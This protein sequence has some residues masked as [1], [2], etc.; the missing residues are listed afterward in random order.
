MTDRSVV[1]RLRL[2]VGNFV[3]NAGRAAAAT[4]QIGT[5]AEDAAR[6]ASTRLGAVTSS[7]EKNEKEWRT[8]GTAATAFGAAAVAGVG[9]AVVAY[10]NFDAQMSSVQAATMETTDNMERLREAAIQAG[11]DTVFSATEAAQ[12]IE[13]LAKAGVSTEDILKG[14]LSGALDLAA[15]GNISVA[16]A[17]ETAASALKQFKL[18]GEQ[19]SHVA[20]LLAAGA[21]KAQGGVS[22]MGQ[23]LN[24]AGLVASQMGLSIEETVGSLT[25][26]ASAGLIGSDAGT[27][28]RAMLLRLANPTQESADLMSDLGLSFYD[29]QGNF[30]GMEGVAG[31]LQDRMA[32]LTQEQ[33]N[34]ALATLFG[35]DAIR[36]ASILYTEG[37]EGVATWTDEVDQ[38]GFAAEQ[39]AT[40]MDNL[41]GDLEGLGGS[42]E[43][44]LI[45]MGESADGP[46][47]GL[48]QGLDS[49]VDA[50]GNLPTPMLNAAT[51]LGAVVG[52]AS[53]A[54]GALLLVAPQAWE[55]FK[56]FKALNE[57][58]PGVSTGLGKV[59]K[60]AGVLMFLELGSQVFKYAAAAS[61]AQVNSENLAEDLEAVAAGAEAAGPA[62]SELL[63]L[64][65]DWSP[66]RQEVDT[67][68]DAVTNFTTLARE[69]LGENFWDQVDRGIDIAGQDMA[70]LETIAEQLD[71]QLAIMS[72]DDARA[73][74]ETLTSGAIDAGVP[75]E[76]LV[77]LFPQYNALVSGSSEAT[78]LTAAEMESAA[79]SAVT[80]EDAVSQ[81][82]DAQA[83]WI[84]TVAQ[85]DGSFVN[86]LGAW[87]QVIAKNQEVAEETAAATESA[88]DSWEDFY[89]GVTVSISDYLAQLEEQVAAQQAWETNMLLLSGRVSQGVIDELAAMGQ[90]GAPLV[91]GL[92]DA[93]DEE[94]QRFE[95][96]FGER[97]ASATTAFAENLL[98][99]GAVIAAAAGQL[100]EEAV[101][102]IAAKLAS[103][104]M[105]LQEVIA[106]YDLDV[107][108]GADTG[109]AAAKLGKYV[110]AVDT[111]TG[112]VTLDG[113]PLPGEKKLADLLADIGT[114]IEDVTIDGSPVPANLT[115]GELMDRIRRSEGDVTVG[116][117]NFEGRAA[118][119]ALVRTINASSGTVKVGAA[120]S[121]S[122]YGQLSGLAGIINGTS[123]NIKVG[124]TRTFTTAQLGPQIADGG[125]FRGGVKAY[126]DG[127]IDAAGNHVPRVP[128]IAQGGRYVM[129]AEQETGWE[130]YISGK[131]GMRARNLRV[132][133]DTGRLLG[134]PGFADGA[135]RGTFQPGAA[136]VMPAVNVAAPTL[137]GARI[138]GVLNFRR[139]GLVELIDGRITAHG[140]ES[141]WDLAGRR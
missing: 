94:L 19:T 141:A 108:V 56:A 92:V 50:A 75:M 90:E 2:E 69:A 4:K 42:W 107:E 65:A 124:V 82:T 37:A 16:E 114:S 1:T 101:A 58:H 128:Q 140:E 109:P 9:M 121:S 60:A 34:A 136:A 61:V 3:S 43:T 110:V 21:G 54:A 112:T 73:A 133:A 89:D 22:E 80:L 123:A 23:A 111:A 13:E 102:E 55:T 103:G 78:S 116:G 126:A 98:G 18:E 64:G 7:I 5:K 48:V 131:P 40:R 62:L 27:S 52:G 119:T 113:N 86:L 97:S 129:W 79:G 120:P 104:E 132:W 67:T 63:Q 95:D 81:L 118:L 53:L 106:A 135:L 44:L 74:F 66:F 29:A 68:A 36:A 12:G 47:R 8:A 99:S 76:R 46:L 100:G 25:A 11:A 117:N 85:S 91:A 88:E 35:Q 127:G 39:A 26:F 96:L 49:V 138:S 30:I 134:V 115:L 51:G 41:K 72:A 93:S 10:A 105:T 28:F 137:D 71:A 125:L 14:G 84:D 31:Q 20:D 130:S 38:S 6:Q 77:E 32:G 139:D 15:S 122:F 57:A 59:A 24:Q 83:D 70:K 45:R 17:A 87:D 33:R